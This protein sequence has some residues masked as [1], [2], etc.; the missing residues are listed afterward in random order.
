MENFPKFYREGLRNFV[1]Y[2]LVI[3]PKK[4]PSFDEIRKFEIF[5]VEIG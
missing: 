3:D 5:N 2:S 4:R 1:N